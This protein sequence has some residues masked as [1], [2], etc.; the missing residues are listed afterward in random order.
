MSSSKEYKQFILEQL[1]LTDNITCKPMMGEFLLYCNNILFGGIYDNRLLIKIVGGNKKY[2][3]PE[4]IPYS[5][6]KP[7]YFVGDVDNKELLTEIVL[8]TCQDLQ[9]SKKNKTNRKNKR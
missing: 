5:G 9:K 3:M 6:A 7:M 1:S 8:A 2:N 4:Q